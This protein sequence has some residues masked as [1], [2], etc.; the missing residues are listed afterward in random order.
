MKFH[1]QNC[2]FALKSISS[3]LL[4]FS[5]I[6]FQFCEAKFHSARHSI[7][8]QN[9]RRVQVIIS[10]LNFIGTWGISSACVACTCGSCLFA[11]EIQDSRTISRQPRQHNRQLYNQKRR[12]SR[13]NI[14]IIP[15]FSMSFEAQRWFQCNRR[16]LMQT[17]V[18][19]CVRREVADRIAKSNRIVN[20]CVLRWFD[21]NTQFAPEPL[22]WIGRYGISLSP[23]ME[24]IV[25]QT[26]T[27]RRL[28][29]CAEHSARSHCEQRIWHTH[30]R[31]HSNARAFIRN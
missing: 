7:K 27:E 11:V 17:H 28:G 1:Q 12:V 24:L 21:I 31:T 2:S 23:I 29:K 14:T 22:L 20:V 30:T 25:I 5:I 3:F 10:K 19:R 18:G 26:I 9:R 6:H 13:G 8:Y 16:C 4:I 15:I